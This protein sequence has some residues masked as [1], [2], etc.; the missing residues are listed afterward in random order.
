MNIKGQFQ[1]CETEMAKMTPFMHNW[2]A[3]HMLN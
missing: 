1:P 2:E 3:L